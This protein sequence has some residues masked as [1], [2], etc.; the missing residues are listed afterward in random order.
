MAI[1]SLNLMIFLALSFTSISH[2]TLDPTLTATSTSPPTTQPPQDLMDH[3]IFSLT[4]QLAPILSHLGFNELA[5]ATPSLSNDTTTASAPYTIFASFD[6]SI[7]TCISCS[8][9][10]LLREHM[11]P[12]LF[13]IDYLRKL[14]FG[15]KI[16]TLSPGRCVTV[17]FNAY[18]QKNFTIQK[19]FV[20]REE[21]THPDL[22][23][24]GLIIIHGLQGNISQLSP[25]SCDV[26]RMTSLSFPFPH[27][28]GQNDHLPRQ[29]NVA[30]MRFMLRD[31]IL[32]LRNNGFSVLSLA[33]K[34]KYAELVSLSNLTIFAL[35]DVSIFSGSF[36][37][38]SNVRF[39]IVPNQLLT[40]EDM[41]RLPVGTTLTTLDREQSLVITTAGGGI[42]KNKMRINYVRIK[43]ADM[44]RNLNVIVHSIYLPFPHIHP[45][46]AVSDATLGVGHQTSTVATIDGSCEALDKQGGCGL[47]QVNH[48]RTQVKPHVQ[49]N[50]DHLGL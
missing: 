1:L 5:T 18:D 6:T 44:I 49:G 45:A 42:M 32:R 3:T 30:L 10:S 21:I 40:I 28:R 4:S 34:I 39:H 13:T 41:E 19:I 37:Y 27:D 29:Q 12:G 15:T 9:P 8:I 7:H 31:S 46:A 16:E 14:A 38:I 24:N 50:E 25:S 22:F 26:E 20:G 33:M 17:T 11:V 47:S 48:V 36:S 35:D 2:S 43:V 23:N